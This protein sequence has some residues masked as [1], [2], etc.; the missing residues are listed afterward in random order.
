MR[1]RCATQQCAQV[2]LS[3]DVAEAVLEFLKKYP[4]VVVVLQKV[5]ARGPSPELR[6]M[7]VRGAGR[8]RV[9]SDTHDCVQAALLNG[10]DACGNVSRT[11]QPR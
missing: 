7:R 3:V 8:L 2:E 10:L 6:M 11:R 1:A 4:G 5:G 9:T